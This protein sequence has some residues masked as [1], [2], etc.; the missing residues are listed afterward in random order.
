MGGDY[1]LRPGR[2]D[3]T[4][5]RRGG[6]RAANRGG[7]QGAGD[8]GG[9]GLCWVRLDGSGGGGRKERL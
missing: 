6:G 7:C 4:G 2:V 3:E 9:V 1:R 5:V 8:S